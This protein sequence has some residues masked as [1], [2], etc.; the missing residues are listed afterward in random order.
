MALSAWVKWKPAA[1][2]MM[3]G[4]FFVASAFA[5]LTNA[6]L[7]TRWG[8]LF[9]IGHVIGLIWTQLFEGSNPTT[10]GAVFFRAPESEQLPVWTCWVALIVILLF[11]LF[12]LSRKI[13]GAEV[14]R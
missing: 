12:M 10:N 9:N 3:F 6:V 2:G 8:N 4:V 13:R 1:G 11:C 5:A 7:R 14:V